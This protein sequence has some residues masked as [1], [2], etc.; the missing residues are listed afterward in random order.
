M[1][2]WVN[3]Q[4][5]CARALCALIRQIPIKRC[6]Q[7]LDPTSFLLLMLNIFETLQLI[8]QQ[9]QKFTRKHNPPSI[10]TK[11]HSHFLHIS[12]H[13]HLKLS[14]KF[15]LSLYYYALILN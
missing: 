12:M 4:C 3:R 15:K 6:C 5:S 9:G 8:L 13:N 11:Q 7:P 2:L 14:L 10:P 1:K